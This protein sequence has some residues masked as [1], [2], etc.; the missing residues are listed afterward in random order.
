MSEYQKWTEGL[1]GILG[2][3]GGRALFEV[4]RFVAEQS[5]R[6]DDFVRGAAQSDSDGFE[7]VSP[8]AS[9]AP[10]PGSVGD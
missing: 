3:S 9:D 4:H 2:E 6:M 7:D 1:S 10:D 5:A 8:A